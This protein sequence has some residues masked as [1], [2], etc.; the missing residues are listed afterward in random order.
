MVPVKTLI[1]HT[2]KG[3]SKHKNLLSSLVNT[4]SFCSI[5]TENYFWCSHIFSTMK[6]T[7]EN[8]YE[9]E[10]DVEED[11]DDEP[12]SS[13]ENE[14]LSFVDEYLVAFCGR[15]PFRQ[16]M[17]RKLAK[18]NIKI[19]AAMP[20]ICT[21]VNTL[22]NHLKK[23]RASGWYL[24]WLKDWMVITLHVIIFFFFFNIGQ[25]GWGTAEKECYHVGD[26]EK[27]Q[28][29]ASLWA[30]CDEEQEGPHLERHNQCWKVCIL[31]RA[32]YATIQ[33]MFF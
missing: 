4:L 22:G 27:K 19:R 5:S 21:L 20:R 18:Y 26:S 7:E 30:A 31:F 23:V 2:T 24:T 17:L 28:A 6:V 13:D 11:P 33:V 25:P 16:Y 32:A 12:S 8:V 14:T 9:T 3:W 15:C 10:D 1:V 29:R